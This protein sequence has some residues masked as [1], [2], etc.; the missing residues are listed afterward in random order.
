MSSIIKLNSTEIEKLTRTLDQYIASKT[1]SA[2]ST[3]FSEDFTHKIHVL[4]KGISEIREIKLA[5]D[6]ITMCGVRLNGKGD[7]HIEICYTIKIKHAKKIAAKL[8]SQDKIEEID[9]MGMSA[10]QEVANIMTGSF[11]NAMSHV[12]GFTVNLSVPDY[13]QGELIPL[14]N[15]CAQDVMNTVDSVVVA[16]VELV[17]QESGI[18]IHMIIMQNPANARKL[19][20]N[21]KTILS[22]KISSKNNPNSRKIGGQNSELDSLISSDDEVKKIND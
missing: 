10:I 13:A 12:T 6:E 21:Q 5:S 7:T 2:L 19:L 1:S 16:D 17:G 22:D 15:V 20:A 14:V 18:K 8:L 4:E 11:F 3:L 9:Q